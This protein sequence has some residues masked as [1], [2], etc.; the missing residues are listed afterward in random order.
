M[1]STH[2][3]HGG[4]LAGQVLQDGPRCAAA[5][6]ALA[7]CAGAAAAAFETVAPVDVVCSFRHRQL[8]SVAAQNEAHVPDGRSRRRDRNARHVVHSVDAIKR[9]E[10]FWGTIPTL[11]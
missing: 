1:C 4:V 7:I 8:Q 6:E 9:V 10:F 3:G 2:A 5:D 11:P